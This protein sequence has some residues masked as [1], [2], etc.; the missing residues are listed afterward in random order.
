MASRELLNLIIEA[1]KDEKHDRRKY[2]LMMRMTNSAL[3]RKQIRFAYVD[4]GIH[5]RLFRNLYHQLTGEWIDV[6]RPPVNL[7]PTLIGNVKTSIDG[8]LGA[9]EMY[10]KSTLGLR[11]NHSGIRCLELSSTNRSMLQDLYMYM[12]Y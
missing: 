11:K 5:Y 8:E 1:M 2:F 4:E 7:E 10:R 9:V 6:A 12:R 3:I